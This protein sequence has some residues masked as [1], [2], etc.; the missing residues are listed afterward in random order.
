MGRPKRA[1]L[2][3]IAADLGV[4]HTTVSNAYNNPAKVSKE[5]RDRIFAHARDLHYEG[6]NPAARSLRTGRCGAIGVLFND[7]LSYAFT[8]AHDIAFLRGIST[9]CEEEGANIVL[10]PL[11]DKHPERLD[12]LTAIVDGYILNAPYKSNPTIRKALAR[13]LPTVVVDFDAPGLPSVLTNDR[14]MMRQVVSHLIE[15]GHRNVA[16]VTFPWTENHGEIFGL[17]RDFSDEN[18]VVHERILGCRDAFDAAGIEQRSVL[19]CE[20][21]NSE[22]GGAKAVERLLQR[23]RD[24]TAI[25]CFSDRLA[26]G[27]A[28]ACAALGRPVPERMSVTGYDGI[29]PPGRAPDGPR[30][31]TV[32][33]NAFEKGR[34]AAERLLCATDG[35]AAAIGIDAQFV[36]GDSSAAAWKRTGE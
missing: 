21:L 29:D 34:K 7:Q 24:L 33:Q 14:A 28:A 13:G 16:I 17:D 32:R 35:G 18:Y 3:S 2:K 10:I 36:I 19:V 6:P 5:L 22:E 30:L 1:T 20:T 15:L 4:T 31:T 9:V 27:V 8:D 25:V 11:K 26:H 23:R 12:T